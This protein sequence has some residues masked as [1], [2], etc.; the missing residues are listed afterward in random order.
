MVPAWASS[1]SS[2]MGWVEVCYFGW[3]LRYLGLF[4]MGNFRELQLVDSYRGNHEPIITHGIYP[5][6]PRNQ[7]AKH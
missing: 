2:A 6:D 4:A 7:I 5:N 1:P 3:N